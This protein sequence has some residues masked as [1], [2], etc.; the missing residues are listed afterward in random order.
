MATK[1]P[2]LMYPPL[3]V[4]KKQC[5]MIHC[6]GNCREAVIK[7]L[8][9]SKQGENPPKSAKKRRKMFDSRGAFHFFSKRTRFFQE[10]KD[11]Q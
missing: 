9:V 6:T 8:P 11:F 10:Q 4:F 3:G 2:D 1:R 7:S 5:Q